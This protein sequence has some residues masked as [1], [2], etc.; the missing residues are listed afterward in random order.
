MRETKETKPK[1][2]KEKSRYVGSRLCSCP[3]N[4]G[5]TLM[6]LIIT[7]VLMLILASITVNVAINGGLFDYAKEAKD[8]TEI[9]SEKEIV[10]QAGI[11]AEGNSKT[12]RVTI[13]DMKKALNS[14]T[15]ENTAT[16]IDTGDTITVKFNE[17]NRCY[18]ID[19]KGNVEYVGKLKEKTLTVQCTDS[20]GKILGEKTYTILKNKYSI[21]PPEVEGYESAVEKIEGEIDEN[22]TISQLYYM[23]FDDDTTLVFTG[24]DESGNTTTDEASIVSYM[25]GDGSTTRGNGL[26]ESTI[27][28]I[29]KIP[30]RYK[31]KTV[32]QVGYGA[33]RYKQNI[34][35]AYIGDNIEI[36][37]GYA[38]ANTNINYLV[39]GK[40]VKSIEGH[41]FMTT[42]KLETI[43][44][45]NA[46]GSYG[47]C[48]SG[49]GNWKYTL[50]SD[51]N[52]AYKVEENIL[53]SK[54]GKTL[55]VCPK[56]FEGEF[57]TNDTVENIAKG[58]FWGCKYETIITTSNITSIGDYAFSTS[59][60]KC[61]EI[62]ENIK[63]I[64]NH[65]FS[66]S[67]PNTVIIN[68]A[69]Y[70]QKI[71]DD[72]SYYL[73]G[74][75]AITVYIREDITTIGSYITENYSVA[76]SDKTGYVKYVK[77]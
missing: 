55:I 35:E 19:S 28:G 38:F 65:T 66:Q 60:V 34:I 13:E 18:E 17:S 31:G 41:A 9:A 75:T 44:F 5:I 2:N 52:N 76:T 3:K 33:F 24:L 40:S 23:I 20:T 47:Q 22:K 63:G 61:I 8:S 58:A 30:E 53:Y 43:M 16:A 37:L 59:L 71:T 14:I 54:D 10:I 46:M 49:C 62:G 70:A 72:T 25:V 50:V 48:F 57:I 68:S 6:A 45:K 51:N 32:T 42:P 11:I 64:S 26:K 27:Q 1:N 36:I 29:L 73:A 15:E 69:N 21:T 12:G 74:G 7:I 4:K 67:S 77:N 39:I 56:G